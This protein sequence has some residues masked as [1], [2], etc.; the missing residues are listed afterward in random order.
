MSGPQV[1]GAPLPN[2]VGDK[3][4][5]ILAEMESDEPKSAGKV[6][7]TIQQGDDTLWKVSYDT[8]VQAVE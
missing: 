2:K 5:E 3:L 8:S 7:L 6:E 4:K 1:S